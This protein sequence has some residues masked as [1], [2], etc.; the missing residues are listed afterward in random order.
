MALDIASVKRRAHCKSIIIFI[1]Q[2]SLRSVLISIM[3][4]ERIPFKEEVFTMTIVP[5]Q[6]YVSWCTM[7][8]TISSTH[9]VPSGCE[10]FDIQHSWML[11][12]AEFLAIPNESAR[13]AS[14]LNLFRQPIKDLQGI[15]RVLVSVHKLQGDS[16]TWHREDILTISLVLQIFSQQSWCAEHRRGIR[17]SGPALDYYWRLST[18]PHNAYIS[19]CSFL[20]GAS[21]CCC[22]CGFSSFQF[23]F[24]FPGVAHDA[25]IWAIVEI[26]IISHGCKLRV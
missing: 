10:S 22:V 20:L 26:E 1:F 4:P 14:S 6:A 23:L 16:S 3:S 11:M 9:T 2:V 19:I 17:R 24:Y 5:S 12:V 8:S 18:N 15:I 25:H 21:L 13:A 7:S